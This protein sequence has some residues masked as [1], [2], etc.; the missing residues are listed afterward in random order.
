LEDQRAQ[1]YALGYLGGIYEQTTQWS[2][3]Q[4]LTQ[5]ALIL[6]QAINAPDIGYRWQWQLGRILKGQG[7]TTGAIASHSSG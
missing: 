5:Q 7:D 1:A 2:N 6:A 3:A 4:K